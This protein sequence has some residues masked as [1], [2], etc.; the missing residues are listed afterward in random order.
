MNSG[1]ACWAAGHLWKA[2]LI[3]YISLAQGYASEEH[4]Q[5]AHVGHGPTAYN[6]GPD[7]H[8]WDKTET[9]TQHGGLQHMPLWRAA[10]ATEDSKDIGGRFAVIIPR[11]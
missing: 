9:G 4:A 8:R 5:S 2:Q 1:V 10:G 3:P 11:E 6:I 7:K